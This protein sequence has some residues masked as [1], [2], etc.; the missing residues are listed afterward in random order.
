MN[1]LGLSCYYHDSAACLVCDGEIAAAAQEERFDRVKNSPALPINAIN[2]CLAERG[3][4]VFDLDLVAFHEKPYLKFHRVMMDHLR[5]YPFSLGNFLRTMPHW[6]EERLCLPIVIREVTGYDGEMVF[7]KHHLSHAASA[8]LPSGM[9]ESALLT[10]DGVGEWATMASGIAKG[11]SIRIDREV[12]YPDSLGLLYT[13]VTTLLGFEALRGE[14]KVMGLASYGRPSFMEEF[15]RLAK[16]L[17][18]GSFR[19]DQ[20]FF[21]FNRGKRM[22]SRKMERLLGP[23]RA[24]GEEVGQRHMDIAASLQLFTEEALLRASRDIKSSAGGDNLCLS[25]G[26]FLNC[27]ANS[28]IKDRTPWANVFIQPAAGDAGGALGAAVYAAGVLSG[29]SAVAPMR[30]AFLGPAFDDGRIARVLD[31]KGIA[32]KTMRRDEI[33]AFTAQGLARGLVTGWF[34]GRME[35]GPRALGNRSILAD[36]R[37]PE[38]KDKINRTVKKREW[39][40][41][42][43]PAVLEER[44]GEFFV[45][46]GPSPFMLLTADVR[47]DKKGV[48]PAVTHVD[49]T[50]RLQT[51]NSGDNPLFRDLIAAF[52]EIT[53]VP[54]VLNT[55]FN[56]RGEPVVCSPE[57]ALDVFL[58]SRMDRLVL[59]VHVVDREERRV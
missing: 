38:M 34:Q 12:L 41:P 21:G 51:V 26:L 15:G 25:G 59:G 33:A 23:A 19:L 2:Y 16:V 10:A 44:A 6:L 11:R 8:F 37:D 57:D 52:Y 30:N 42:Y 24:A 5:D 7:V 18:D 22:Y 31:S 35:F 50:A 56:L 29:G 9:P 36:P 14:G 3:L 28:A 47:E 49:G 58:R 20:S 39:F 46:P 54:V 13:A 1:V 32:Y 48:I 40:R 55:S 17:P 43:A 45:S 4:T 27:V 53:G